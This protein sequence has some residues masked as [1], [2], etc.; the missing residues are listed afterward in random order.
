MSKTKNS[1]HTATSSLEGYRI[2]W[3]KENKLSESERLLVKKDL[4]GMSKRILDVMKRV[5]EEDLQDEGPVARMP[6]P[7]H[8]HL[9][10]YLAI[11]RCNEAWHVFVETISDC[12]GEIVGDGEQFIQV[13]KDGEFEEDVL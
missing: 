1:S 9:Q 13:L 6:L 2:L 7:R 8:A 3:C 5:K 4:L 12:I 11:E 10:A